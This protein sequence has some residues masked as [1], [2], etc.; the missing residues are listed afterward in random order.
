VIDRV[1]LPG[2][3]LPPAQLGPADFLPGGALFRPVLKLEHSDNT[4][5]L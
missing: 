2:R 1:L 3:S 5:I 4:L